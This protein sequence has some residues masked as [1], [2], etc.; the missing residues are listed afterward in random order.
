MSDADELRAL[1]ARI[2]AAMVDERRTVERELHDGPLQR[3]VALGVGLQL[4][5]NL[6]DRDPEA[7]RL[8]LDE[9][10]SDVHEALEELRQLCWRIYPSLLLDRGIVDA[11]KAAASEAPVAA[12]VE[13][14]ALGRYPAE[15]EATVYFVCAE[16][17]AAADGTGATIRLREEAGRL[18]FDVLTNTRLPGDLAA[19]RDRVAALGGELTVSSGVVSGTIPIRA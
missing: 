8:R 15:V 11:L 9:L 1:L 12:R 7:A 2:A 10:R 6:L 19:A 3:L 16:A 18:C 13:A 17:L 5:G 4:A 14:T